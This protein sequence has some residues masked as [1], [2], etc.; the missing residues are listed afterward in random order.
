MTEAPSIKG[1]VLVDLVDDV[2]ALVEAGDPEASASL[3]AEDCQ[4]LEKGISQ[5]SWYDIG[6]YARMM[7]LMRDVHGRGSNEY[8]VDRGRNRGRKLIDAG[9]YQQLEYV[10]RLQVVSVGTLEKRLAAHARDLRLLATLSRSILSFT[11]WSVGVD[12]ESGDRHLIEVCEA[13]AFPDILGYSTEGFIDAMANIRGQ[14]GLWKYER[15]TPSDVVFRMTRP[16]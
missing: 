12:P 8:V 7:K 3:T 13:E 9:L 15:R 11:T 2:R 14:S 5:A 10:G 1:S 6:F 4:T 16:L